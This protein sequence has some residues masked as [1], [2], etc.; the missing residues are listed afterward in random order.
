MAMRRHGGKRPA[1]IRAPPPVPYGS[2]RIRFPLEARHPGPGRSSRKSRLDRRRDHPLR[3]RLGM[4]RPNQILQQ[5]LPNDLRQAD[6][7]QSPKCL[8]RVPGQEPKKASSPSRR[9]A[10]RH[11]LSAEIVIA[12]LED[13]EDYKAFEVAITADYDAQSAV[14]RELVLRL[15]GLLWRLRRPEAFDGHAFTN[16]RREECVQT[17]GEMAR[18][19]AHPPFPAVH[20]AAAVCATRLPCQIR[21]K[22]AKIRTASAV[23]M[24]ICE[25]SPPGPLQTSNW[26]VKG[27]AI[28]HS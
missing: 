25:A 22:S 7:R 1:L 16:N 13:A 14:E 9:N 20:V 15:A 26:T 8:L 10:V 4:G 11:G 27:E 17:P 21:R 2:K 19:A 6:C 5:R 18:S 3:R 23:Q 12:A 28:S 24:G